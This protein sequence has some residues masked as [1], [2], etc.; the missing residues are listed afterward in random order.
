VN[1]TNA[2]WFSGIGYQ[3]SFDG[4]VHLVPHG[5]E[6]LRQPSYQASFQPAALTQQGQLRQD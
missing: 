4:S 5:S 3:N 1:G 2:V 6:A